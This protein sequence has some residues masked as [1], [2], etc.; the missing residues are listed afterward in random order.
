MP[1][2]FSGN[3]LLT[4]RSARFNVS[5]NYNKPRLP[6]TKCLVP[7]TNYMNNIFKP[8]IDYIHLDVSVVVPT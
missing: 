4:S 2:D 8:V 3:Y 7:N 6:A 5:A 1:V